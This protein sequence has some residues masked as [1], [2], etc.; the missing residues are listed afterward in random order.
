MAAKYQ[1]LQEWAQENFTTPPTPATLRKWCKQGDIPAKPIGKKWFVII[2]DSEHKP[3]S[4]VD[5]L[6]SKVLT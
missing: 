5:K 3:K 1:P 6:V 2:G 4:N